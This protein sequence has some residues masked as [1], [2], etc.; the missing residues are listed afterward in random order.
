[1]ECASIG[2]APAT[3]DRRAFVSHNRSAACAACV[4][5]AS[6]R[7]G[8]AHA[9]R[10]AGGASGCPNGCRACAR[11]QRE[12]GNLP[13]HTSHPQGRVDSQHWGEHAL[14]ERR[15]CRCIP[16]DSRTDAR[17][18]PRNCC[19]SWSAVSRRCGTT[20]FRAQRF[21]GGAR[22]GVHADM[23]VP[24]GAVQCRWRNCPDSQHRSRHR[25]GA[26]RSPENQDRAAALLVRDRRCRCGQSTGNALLRVGVSS[27]SAE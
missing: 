13:H 25:G 10:G 2:G 23:F 6:D 12:R 24:G 11:R 5:A 9:P 27:S 7:V 16:G 22:Q 20:E 3:P 8:C 19:A 4:C 21:P 17:A 14:P 18:K 15:W 1:M 26:S